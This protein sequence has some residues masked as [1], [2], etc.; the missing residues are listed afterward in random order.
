MCSHTSFMIMSLKD[1]NLIIRIQ[2]SALF[3]V[4]NYSSLVLRVPEYWY[5]AQ[6]NH[7]CQQKDCLYEN[8]TKAI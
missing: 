7:V 5:T 1:E 2:A 3:E 4:A 6:S 8:N